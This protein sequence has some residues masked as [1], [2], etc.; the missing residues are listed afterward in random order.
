MFYFWKYFDTKE[1]KTYST[2]ERKH[3]N[4]TANILNKF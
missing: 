4:E 3:L 1:V 2:D